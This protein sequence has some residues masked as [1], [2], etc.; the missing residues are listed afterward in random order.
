VIDSG[1]ARVAF[2]LYPSRALLAALV[3]RRRYVQY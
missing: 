3:A 1:L 2:A